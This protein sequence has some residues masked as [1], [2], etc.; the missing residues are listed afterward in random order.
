MPPL[1]TGSPG[2]LSENST[3][4]ELKSMIV[5]GLATTEEDD[6]ELARAI[7]CLSG[8]VFASLLGL[9]V[10]EGLLVDLELAE[11]RQI[12]SDILSRYPSFIGK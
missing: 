10:T 6:K 9:P 7:C 4:N 11:A 5:A 3:P 8:S 1:L 2:V 12:A